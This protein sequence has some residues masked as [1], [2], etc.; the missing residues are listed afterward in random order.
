MKVV[1]IVLILSAI[2]SGCAGGKYVPPED[3]ICEGYPSKVS[4]K[5]NL[6]L[7]SDASFRLSQGN[8]DPFSHHGEQR[9]AYDFSVDTGS[10]VIAARKGVVY[11]TKE[12]IKNGHGSHSG[13]YIYIQHD[14]G[15]IAAYF[16]LK[17]NGVIV[18]PGDSVMQG[19]HIGY[20]GNTGNSTGEHL[21][22]VVYKNEKLDQ[23]IPITFAN[24]DI[25]QNN[26]KLTWPNKV[27]FPTFYKE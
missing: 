20:S 1:G 2:V 8:C 15:T 12:S 25:N 10:P 22:F 5:Y 16:H 14:D 18:S 9:Y 19:D 17:H 13:N 11:K 6:P 21:H 26:R 7:N 4:S 27:V 24:A 3:L 23:S